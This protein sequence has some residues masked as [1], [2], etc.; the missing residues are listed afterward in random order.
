MISDILETI[1]QGET[2]VAP[3]FR[4]QVFKPTPVTLPFNDQVFK[5]TP[6]TPITRGRPIPKILGDAQLL[7]ETALTPP[8]PAQQQI[9]QNIMKDSAKKQPS[10]YQGI[11]SNISD[12]LKMGTKTTDYG[13][14]TKYEKFH[15]G[16]D[17]ANVG[18]TPIPSTIE[19]TVVEIVTGKKQGDKGFGNQVVIVDSQGNKHKFS[20]LDKI[21][22][23]V[24]Q[25]VKSGET[26][27]T[28][29]NTGST[30]SP[31]GTGTGTHLDY[32]IVDAYNKYINPYTYF[33]S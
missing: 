20:H 7:R 15:P 23:K 2:I 17:I 28:M 31:S 14:S 13:G 33:K 16:L 4:D 27:A 1:R 18:G 10:S 6:V 24:G 8:F 9:A 19:G 25:K 32:R 11:V 5:P 12:L 22:T 21:W 3:P 29:G 26:I 30:Y